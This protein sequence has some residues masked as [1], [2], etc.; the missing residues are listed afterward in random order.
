MRA[1]WAEEPVTAG[2]YLKQVRER[3]SIYDAAG[4]D[5]L[6]ELKAEERPSEDKW[7]QA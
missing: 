4:L 6:D 2:Q 7:I 3:G 1:R 5:A